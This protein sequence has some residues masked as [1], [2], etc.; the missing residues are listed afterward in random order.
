MNNKFIKLTLALVMALSVSV[1]AMAAPTDV[2]TDETEI[3]ATPVT[4]T[5]APNSGQENTADAVAL[6]K[7]F[8]DINTNDFAWARPYINDMTEK[9]YI[10][11]YEDGTYRPDNDVTR[12]EALSLFARA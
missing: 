9:G 7:K 2:P 10:S 6:S 11:G 3:T 8:S 1:P 5:G 4:T 12:Q